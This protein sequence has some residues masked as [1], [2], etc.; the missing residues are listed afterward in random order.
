MKLPGV[1]PPGWDTSP[2]QGYPL[3]LNSPVSMWVGRGTLRVKCLAQE[4]NTMSP[5][6]WA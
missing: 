6:S 3:A 2:S 1:L 4:N 5:A